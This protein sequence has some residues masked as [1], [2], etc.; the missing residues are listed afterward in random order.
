MAQMPREIDIDV[1][2]TG[3]A[4]RLAALNA[5]VALTSAQ[6]A[7]RPFMADADDVIASALKFEDYLNGVEDA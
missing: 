6:T 1:N 7:A 2:V 4:T 3:S 5:A